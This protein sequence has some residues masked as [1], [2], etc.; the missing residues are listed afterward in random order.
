LLTGVLEADAAM[1]RF[2]EHLVPNGVFVMSIMSKLWRGKY[3]PAQM[4]WSEWHKLGER[5]RPE[6]GATIRHWI[7]TRYDH[8]QQLE[9]EENRYEV[10]HGDVIVESESYGRSPAVRWYSQRQAVECCERAGFTAV[11]T[12]SGFTLEPASPKDTTFCVIGT[13]A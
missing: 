5:E 6:D 10:L 2:Y 9:H 3:P 1:A 13:R 8:E 11:T 4:Q 12:T 7:R